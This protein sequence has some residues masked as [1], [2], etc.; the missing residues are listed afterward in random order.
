[1]LSKEFS[2]YNGLDSL[3][4]DA[5]FV[6][7]KSVEE[8]M[9]ICKSNESYIGFNTLGY[10]KNFVC[11]ES[12][13][14]RVQCFGPNDGLY[15]HTE[16]YINMKRQ[17]VK[18]YTWFDDY[19]YYPFM[20]SSDHDIKHVSSDIGLRNIK[21]MADECG[22]A[23][24]NT[25]G[26]IKSYVKPVNEFI[27]LN[28]KQYFQGLYVKRRKIRV[29]MLCNWCS[30]AKLCE[31]WSVM[32]QGDCKWNDIELTWS[33]DNV[34][35]YVIINKPQP[36]D[37]F[38]PEKT[39]VTHMEPWCYNNSQQWGVKTWGQ[40]ATP[41]ESLFLQVRP[42]TKY[43]NTTFWQLKTS[44]SEFKKMFDIQKRGIISSI[45]S[46]KYFDP[47]HVK[48]IDFLKYCESKNDPMVKIH[49]YN[50]D[51]DHKFKNYMGPHEPGNKDMGIMPYKYYFMPENNQEHNFIT[52][53]IWEPLLCE[54]L[55]FYWGCPNISE[56]IDER[57][58]ILLDMDDFDKSFNIVRDA[59]VTDQWSKRLDVIRREKQK[60]LDYYNF[61]PTLERVLKQ[62]FKL[63]Q[64]MSID[65][66]TYHKYF[67]DV[68]GSK[69]KNVCFLHSC[70][71]GNNSKVLQEMVDDVKNSGLLNV[72][73]MLFIINI[74][75]K[76][77]M[78]DEKIKVINYSENTLL[79]EKPTINLLLLFS[80]FNDC[81]ILYL[82]T[83]GI[84]YNDAH[85]NVRDWRN[86]MMYFL[87]WE[88]KLCLDLLDCYDTVGCNYSKNPCDHYSGN[89]WWTRSSYVKGLKKVV[90][91]VRHDCEWFILEGE[92]KMY[93]VFSSG[94]D[95]YQMPFGK[96]K[97]VGKFNID[98]MYKLDG[99]DVKCVNL[100][101]RD[102]RKREM[103]VKLEKVGVKCDFIEAVD[104]KELVV[105][106]VILKMFRGNDFGSRVGVIGCALSHYG[107]WEMMVRE[108]REMWLILEDDVEFCDNFVF[109][110]N[111][112]LDMMHQK[113]W[114]IVYLGYS[115]R[116]DVR[117]SRVMDI[118]VYDCD[119]NIGGTFGYL[120]KKSG[121]KKFVDFISVNGVKHGI[122][123]LMF[124]YWREM[125]LKHF[126][127]VPRLIFSDVAD[128]VV[129]SDV[130]YDR[131]RLF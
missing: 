89:F 35:F 23:G 104:G 7:N 39:I 128:G 118:C 1:M 100:V 102:D 129:D 32:S 51:N 54:C 11:C 64:G 68:I 122:D 90:S 66:V 40:W 31:E 79:F 111:V 65:E 56:W 70:C 130:Q 34:D 5:T 98:G 20:D 59:I 101:R 81:K 112:V 63:R 106:D 120:I 88:Y 125:D 14:K 19:D 73:D 78:N 53:K 6:A 37:H 86:M 60:V 30:G 95:H 62:T 121:A 103:V 42:H 74:G 45:C 21:L 69:M 105:D 28:T 97:Y 43:L 22:A 47:G 52:E 93:N 18:S 85:L 27:K 99:I 126:Q 10:I 92:G 114:D 80:K 29:K 12:D 13:L 48:R 8:L 3:G 4:H 94:I 107:L 83:K 113:D 25:L 108:E 55:C 38:I 87:V 46:S 72:L 124:R 119:K 33:N 127:V 9:N 15:V 58:F 82:H 36:G 110:V 77:N 75:D 2:Y 26:F 16:R 61:Y 57:A 115:V 49:I 71:I 17:G 116:G 131:N 91:D 41:D 117:D 123:Y 96:E 109:K 24:F 76:I 84:S 44:Y 50:H 67:S